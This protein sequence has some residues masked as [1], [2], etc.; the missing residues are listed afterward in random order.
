MRNCFEEVIN[1][2]ATRISAQASPDAQ[3]LAQLEAADL[4]SASE[5]ARDSHQQSGKGYTIH[6][7]HC[8]ELY[9]WLPDLNLREWVTVVPLIALMVWM[10]IYTQSFLPS[11]S[12]SNAHMLVQAQSKEIANAR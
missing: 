4:H 8:G 9:S 2:Q 1:A 5:S 6:C 12:A 3:S 10:G 11:I 7:Q